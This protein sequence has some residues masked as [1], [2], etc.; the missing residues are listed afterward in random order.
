M[1]GGGPQ[2]VKNGGGPAE[3]GGQTLEAAAAA[4]APAA[5]RARPTEGRRA[6]AAA[7]AAAQ[8]TALRSGEDVA[9][10]NAA[11][12]GTHVGPAGA[13]VLPGVG[14]LRR[15]NVRIGQI[16]RLRRQHRG[17]VGARDRLIQIDGPGVP[18][19]LQLAHRL[20]E[21]GASLRTDAAP[22]GVDVIG[23]TP[24]P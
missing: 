5:R 22:P 23:H 10:D 1:K 17:A 4:T 11:D 20:R 14:A 24:Y 21:P 16:L 12:D 15:P 19:G 6:P 3:V 13:A 8:S 9:D 18:G 2:P 7:H